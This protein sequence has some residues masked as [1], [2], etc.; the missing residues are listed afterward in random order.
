MSNPSQQILDLLLD[1]MKKKSLNTASLSKKSGIDKKNL[2]R[3]FAGKEELTV[4]QLMILSAALELKENDFLQVP[5]PSDEPKK[6]QESDDS[7]ALKT[8]DSSINWTPNPLGIQAEQILRI[9]FALGVD[10]LF[11]AETKYLKESKVP[12]AVL[13]K[14]SPKMPIRLDAAYHHHYRPHYFEEGLE[15]RLS[16]DTVY[17]CFFPWHSIDQVTCFVFEEEPESEESEEKIVSLDEQTNAAP[18]LRIVK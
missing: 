6:P 14:F 2:K 18:F 8:V 11:T 3:I 4:N 17:T 9:G 7:I 16:F 1:V 5:L 10:I 15:I 13:K 12:E